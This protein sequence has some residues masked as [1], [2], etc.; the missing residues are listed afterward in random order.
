[1]V[2][3]RCFVFNT[4]RGSVR[5]SKKSKTQKKQKRPSFQEKSYTNVKRL[6]SVYDDPLTQRDVLILIVC[7]FIP[8]LKPLT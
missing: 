4:I 5:I 1:M 3:T 7:V 6:D 8:V 2:L